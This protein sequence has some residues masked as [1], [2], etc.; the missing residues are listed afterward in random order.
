MTT[1]PTDHKHG[2]KQ[3]CYVIH[4]CRCLTC[5]AA[6]RERELRRR[7]QIAY[8]RPTTDLVDAEPVR[9]HLRWL[10]TQGIGWQRAARLAEVPSG[11]VSFLMYGGD[12]G[13]GVEPPS[14]RIKRATADA[15]LAL[16]PSLELLGE[17]ALIP[18]WPYWRRIE[19]LV[20]MGYSLSRI[21]R[22][23][24]VSPSNFKRASTITVRRAR[25]LICVYEQW[26]MVPPVAANRGEL[27]SIAR[28]KTLANLNGWVPPLAWDDI[29]NR[30]ERP[31]GAAA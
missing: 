21:A 4:K 6:N 13:R 24:G 3:T 23:I 19:A 31:K 16:Q 9:A 2:E 12:R 7:K 20:C 27:V 5:N 8:G 1:C 25:R 18:S 26:S 29:D 28:A 15:I 10:S 17:K 22:A 30:R 14:R 11:V